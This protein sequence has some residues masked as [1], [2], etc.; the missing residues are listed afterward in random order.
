MP[1]V[2]QEM[3]DLVEGNVVAAIEQ[4]EYISPNMGEQGIDAQGTKDFIIQNLKLICR[5]LGI[6]VPEE[7]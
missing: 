1:E 7:E 6:Q 5:H 2:S 4:A 3:L